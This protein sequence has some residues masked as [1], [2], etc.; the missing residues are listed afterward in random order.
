MCIWPLRSAAKLECVFSELSALHPI[1][2][3]RQLYDIVIDDQDFSWLCVNM[4]A[5]NKADIMFVRFEDRL[6][7]D[8]ADGGQTEIADKRKDCTA[9]NERKASVPR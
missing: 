1:Q 7:V 5:R 9:R 6:L 4:S 3:L 8:A 2:T